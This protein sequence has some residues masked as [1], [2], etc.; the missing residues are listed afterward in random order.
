MENESRADRSMTEHSAILAAIEKRDPA[1]A[2]AAMR[3]HV[4]NAKKHIVK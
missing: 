2:A 4:E 3:A 1:A